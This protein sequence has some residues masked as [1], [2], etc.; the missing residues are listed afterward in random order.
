MAA[1]KKTTKKKATR[2]TSTRKKPKPIQ[3]WE[4]PD[5]VEADEQAREL[6]AEAFNKIEHP[7]QRGFLVHYALTARL[8]KAA[9]AAGCS[10]G[11]HYVWMKD[12]EYANGFALAEQLAGRYLE[13]IAIQRAVHGYLKPIV[14]MGKVTAVVR[15]A[16]HG[17]LKEI[18]RAHLPERY[19]RQRMELTGAGGGPINTH[20]TG[21]LAIP[22]AAGSVEE[23]IKENGPGTDTPPEGAL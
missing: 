11:S 17:L 6:V 12:P 10:R 2:R 8:G 5:L 7:Q 20:G 18:L 4:P 13:E 16:D 22:V 9:D 19:G 3:V 1:K 15:T 23:W 21:V 14:H